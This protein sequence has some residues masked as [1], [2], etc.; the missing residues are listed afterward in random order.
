MRLILYDD[1]MEVIT[2][3]EE[4]EPVIGEKQ[5]IEKVQNLLLPIE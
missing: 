4:L 1:L 5:A 3:K 2:L